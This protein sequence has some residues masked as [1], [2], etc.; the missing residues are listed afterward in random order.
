MERC[1]PTATSGASCAHGHI[2]WGAHRVDDVHADGVPGHGLQERL[3]GVLLG[4]HVL[5]Q[6]ARLPPCLSA[7]RVRRGGGCS[8]GR[9][10]AAGP[11]GAGAG[12]ARQARYQGR[13]G[14]AAL[15]AAEE[16]RQ[17]SSAQ[18]GGV[19]VP[20]EP[21]ANAAL[22]GRL[23]PLPLLLQLA[24]QLRGGAAL[25]TGC[26]GSCSVT[27]QAHPGTKGGAQVGEPFLQVGPVAPPELGGRPAGG[28]VLQQSWWL[29]R[30][31][32]TLAHAPLSQ[33]RHACQA[34][35]SHCLALTG[36][37]ST[38]TPEPAIAVPL[39]YLG[40]GTSI[41]SFEAP[42]GRSR[43]LALAAPCSLSW[44]AGGCFRPA[45]GSGDLQAA[46]LLCAASALA[47]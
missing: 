38:L 27:A 5:R 30:P 35:K 39:G 1:S 25:S 9:L 12:P 17:A 26:T 28:G 40:C 24:L 42:A 46:A 45:P 4:Q 32:R 15:A 31:A 33:G 6:P 44:T 2:E 14:Q 20:E 21:P 34:W 36:S 47:S 13:D 41:S 11:A 23:Q 37:T 16:G 43:T 10:T 8:P 7:R 18:K 19:V 3:L 22:P 29:S